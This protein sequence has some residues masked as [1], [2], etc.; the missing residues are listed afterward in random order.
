MSG[1][2]HKAV[3]VWTIELIALNNMQLFSI[4]EHLHMVKL[5]VQLLE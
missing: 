3:Y 2:D 4:I 1:L 5:D